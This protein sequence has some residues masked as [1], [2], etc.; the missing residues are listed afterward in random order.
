VEQDVGRHAALLGQILPQRAQ[1]LEQRAV[2]A[3]PRHLLGP[4]LADAFV[5]L[6]GQ[7]PDQTHGALT[8]HDFPRR[9]VEFQDRIVVADLV[10]QLLADQLADPFLDDVALLVLKQAERA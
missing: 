3:F 8:L 5:F 10:E 9:R 4:G 2:D 1:G 7:R 6:A